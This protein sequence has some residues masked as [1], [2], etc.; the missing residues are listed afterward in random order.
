LKVKAITIWH[1]LELGGTSLVDIDQ[2]IK[3]KATP[4]RVYG[5]LTT[6]AGIKSWYTP[7]V[8]GDGSVTSVWHFSFSGRPEFRW[9]ILGSVPMRHVAWKCVQGPG[10]SVGTTA[11]F[12]ISPT[13]DGRTL[14]EFSHAGWPGTHGNYRK[15]NT[16]WGILLHHLRQYAETG[17]S[18]PHFD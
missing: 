8:V 2:E 12:D 3:I 5:A 11:T 14:L 6:A 18:A 1:G 17:K 4:E 13:S 15:C 10:D 16:L 7:R 9:Q